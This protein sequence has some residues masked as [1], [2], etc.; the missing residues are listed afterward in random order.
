MATADR[1]RAL[2]STCCRGLFFLLC[3]L[4][5]CGEG[6]GPLESALPVSVAVSV[7]AAAGGPA[8]AFDL[9][10]AVRV[11]VLVAGEQ[12][13]EETQAFSAEAETSVRIRLDP[14]LEGRTLQVFVA[15]LQGGADLFRGSG[16]TTLQASGATAVELDLEPVVAA[17][18]M[19]DPVAEFSAL[20]ERTRLGAAAVFATGDTIP[21][22]VLTWES[23]DPEIVML[24]GDGDAV[25]ISEGE[26]R[27]EAST[28]AVVGRSRARVRLEVARIEVRPDPATVPVG[29]TLRFEAVMTDR[30]GTPVTRTPTWISSNP[31]AAPIDEAGVATGLAAGQTTIT[32]RADGVEASVQLTVVAVPLAPANLQGT[33]LSPSSRLYQLTWEDRSSNETRFT[34]ERRNG[35]G[36]W[37]PIGEAGVN[38]TVFTGTG[39]VGENHFRVVACNAQGCSSPSNEL[40]L[41]FVATVPVVETL[42]SPDVGVMR[43]RVVSAT[44]YRYR[45]QYSTALAD[46]EDNS[47]CPCYAETEWS[48]GVGEG[49]FTAPSGYGFSGATLY[50]R[51]V[52]E[53]AFGQAT[54][55]MM[56]LT[57]PD[58]AVVLENFNFSIATVS[59]TISTPPGTA[60]SPVLLVEFFSFFFGSLS[61]VQTSR[62]D[63]ALETRFIYRVTYSSNGDDLFARVWYRTGVPVETEILCYGFS[64]DEG[65]GSSTS[66]IRP[67]DG[68]WAQRPGKGS[69]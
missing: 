42:S 64:C 34:I 63:T 43:G 41:D 15:L 18:V 49:T 13:L 32:A 45:F 60:I 40:L 68:L 23:L 27:V 52:A 51:I 69:R 65:I 61:P 10:D 62:V 66:R 30:S 39:Q 12:V 48:N 14:A 47:E 9:A 54:G 44:E 22:I 53:N 57:F 24:A 6:A 33:I 4:P 36:E 20:G 3:V 7:R 11:R 58:V 16:S 2:P 37:V 46:F 59:V 38:T 1:F 67:T 21:G 5:A 50:Y 35:S 29:E 8:E 55:E 26:A 28:G 25:A 19:E 56:T 17:V 31:L